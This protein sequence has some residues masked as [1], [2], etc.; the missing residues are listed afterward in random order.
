[1]LSRGLLDR[2]PRG[3][4]DEGMLGAL[5]ARQRLGHAQWGPVASTGRRVLR[6]AQPQPGPSS[7]ASQPDQPLLWRSAL[8]RARSLKDAVQEVRAGRL[9]VA[10][11]SQTAQRQRSKAAVE[12]SELRRSERK[13]TQTQFQAATETVAKLQ[14][15]ESQHS[16][17]R[18]R[19][20][21]PPPHHRRRTPQP[22]ARPNDRC[23][24]CA[25]CTA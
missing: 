21:A 18:A 13:R 15:K 16:A 25:G 20:A 4:E 7:S 2:G 17:R 11:V 8:S 12:M 10:G 5:R 3:T 24:G 9:H 22:A 23:S 6:N 14:T 1:M 19:A